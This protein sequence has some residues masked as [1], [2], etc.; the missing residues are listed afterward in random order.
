MEI[1]EKN[2]RYYVSNSSWFDTHTYDIEKI[3]SAVKSANGTQIRTCYRNGLSNQPKVVSFNSSEKNIVNILK[4]V[5]DILKT[6]WII[7]NRKKW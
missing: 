6:Q 7:I 4:S 5:Q 2:I 3:K 1:T